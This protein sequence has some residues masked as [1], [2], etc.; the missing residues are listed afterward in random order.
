MM[1]NNRAVVKYY[2]KFV[3]AWEKNHALIMFRKIQIL[4]LHVQLNHPNENKSNK[5]DAQ[6]KGKNLTSKC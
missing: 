1:A 4:V 5:N 3:I 6:K 2:E